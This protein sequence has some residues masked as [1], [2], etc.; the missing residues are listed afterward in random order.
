MRMPAWRLAMF[1]T[2]PS[3]SV[4]EGR[5]S[6]RSAHRS[7][8]AKSLTAVVGL[9]CPS[10]GGQRTVARQR[11]VSV[12]CPPLLPCAATVERSWQSQYAR[13]SSARSTGSGKYMSVLVSSGS[14]S[15]VL[16]CP[17]APGPQVGS[18]ASYRSRRAALGGVA[19]VNPASVQDLAGSHPSPNPSVNRTSTSGLRPLAAAGYLK[20]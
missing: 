3:V 10:F 7:S 6:T 9:G 15:S 11:R 2:L 5:P 16:R 19:A 4:C 1:D 12:Q 14:C 8:P 17:A 20:R 18:G 13:G